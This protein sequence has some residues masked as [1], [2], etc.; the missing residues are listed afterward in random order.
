[1]LGKNIWFAAAA[2]TLVQVAPQQAGAQEL[3][4]GDYERCSVYERDGDFSGYDS[5]C[6]AERRD[7][8]RYYE[9]KSRRYDS[10]SYYSGVYYC[11]RWANGGN[12]Y[13][14]T[15]Y[16]DGRPPSYAGTYDSTSNGRPCIPN[17]NYYG[18]GYY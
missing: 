9:R 7:A 15:W 8:L 3:S 1:M 2:A 12:G 16:N 10:Q 14:A 5:V 17:P 6:L 13:N 4:D 18:T 11:P